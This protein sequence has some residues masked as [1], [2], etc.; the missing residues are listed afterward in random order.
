VGLPGS[1]SILILD[2]QERLALGRLARC[3]QAIANQLL[4]R[5]KETLPF[6]RQQA[7]FLLEQLFPGQEQTPSEQY[8]GCL[9]A[10]L[11]RLLVISGGPGTG[12]TYLVARIVALLQ[13]LAKKELRVALCA[14]TGKAAARLQ[15]SIRKARAG[16]PPELGATVNEEAKTLHRLLGV[17]SSGDGFRYHQGNPLVLDLLIIDEASMV[18]VE[19]MADLLAALPPR[20]RLI[21]LG[22]HNQLASVEAGS[23]FGD[24]W[25]HTRPDFSGEMHQ[26]LHTLIPGSPAQETSQEGFND[27]LVLL[28][29]S[30]RFDQKSGI[31]QLAA[32]INQGSV[33]AIPE[34]QEGELLHYRPEEREQ[35]E[36]VLLQHFEPLYQATDPEEGFARLQQFR[37]LCCLRRGPRGVEAINR[38]VEELLER[39][40]HIKRH[41]PFYLGRPILVTRNHYGLGLFNGDTGLIWPDSEGHAMAWFERSDGALIPIAPARLPEHETGFALTVHKSQGSEFTTALIVLPEKDH[42]ILSRE[43]LYTAVTRAKKQVI[44]YGDAPLLASAATRPIRRY[45]TLPD[46]LREPPVPSPA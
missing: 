30:Y 9:T 37:I 6:D 7:R 4:E 45:S 34:Q 16:L 44:L 17:R 24:L 42:R 2:Q 43:L 36:Q 18:D 3:E 14:P 11:R 39:K 19:L 12:K 28:T 41:D 8:I 31:G 15:E 33:P 35:L 23:L 13:G 22:D 21:L 1:S 25:S 38:L 5:S 10:L 20:A 29:R 46:R 26:R 40:G 32:A 27:S